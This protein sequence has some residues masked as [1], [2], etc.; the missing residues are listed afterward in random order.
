MNDDRV[1]DPA[2][3]P[4]IVASHLSDIADQRRLLKREKQRAYR[5]QRYANDPV[6]RERMKA[7][8]RS[9][10]HRQSAA[11]RMFRA[12]RNRATRLGLVFAITLED[13][14]AAIPSD[15]RCPIFGFRMLL[16]REPDEAPS[17]DRIEPE[18]GYVKD[19][20]QIISGRANR[21][22]AD[23]YPEELRRIADYMEG[24]R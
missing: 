8:A 18:R 2:L 4:N 23:A 24:K 9:V 11:E 14:E 7:S 1:S 5:R 21:L 3:D 20:I 16:D 10:H 19:N 12:S 17:I 6:Y 13:V 15:M 22:K